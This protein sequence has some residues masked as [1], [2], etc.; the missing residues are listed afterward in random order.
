MPLGMKQRHFLFFLTTF[1][2][3]LLFA[4]C[5]SIDRTERR[6]LVANNVSPVVYDKMMHGEVLS[7]SDIIELSQRQIP[8]SMIIRYLDSTRA[9]YRLD[10]SALAR[11][12]QAK[13]NQEVI[14]F[15]LDT[16]SLFG[17]RPYAG[18]YYAP[19]PY[20]PYGAYYPYYPY[21]YG[22]SAVVVV[23][24]RGHRW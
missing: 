23:G 12:N 13:V 3:L 11:L 19:R 17:P 14:N 21:Y 8:S 6:T 2:A 22:P 15:L 7:L 20:Y 16:P 5:A 10:K 1:L 9:I 24:G 4:G 18:P